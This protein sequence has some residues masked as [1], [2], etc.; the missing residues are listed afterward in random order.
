VA[1]LMAYY[2]TAEDPIPVD[3]VADLDALV[4]RMASEYAAQDGP[5][6]PVAELFRPDPWAEGWVVIRLG[7]AENRGFLAHADAAGSFITTSGGDLDGDPVV[8][9]YQGHVREF[10]SDAEIPLADVIKAAHDLVVTDGQR[11]TAVMWRPWE[12]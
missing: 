5:V 6:P 4:D 8:Y 11:S 9:D 1:A 3:S 12:S 7:I 2:E 10:P